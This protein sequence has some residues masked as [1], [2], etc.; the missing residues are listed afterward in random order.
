MKKSNIEY[1]A[2]DVLLLLDGDMIRIIET[3]NSHF[4]NSYTLIYIHDYIT[5]HMHISMLKVE[6][7]LGQSSEVLAAFYATRSLHMRLNK[8]KNV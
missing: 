6:K 5:W 1:K 8:L 7:N 4:R 2:G 3:E